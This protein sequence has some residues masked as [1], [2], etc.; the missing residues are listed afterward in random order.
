MMFIQPNLTSSA[1]QKKIDKIIPPAR[2]SQLMKKY[3]ITNA[4]S[5]INQTVVV[6]VLLCVKLRVVP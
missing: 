5:I 2:L 1:N 3:G 4:I 6:V